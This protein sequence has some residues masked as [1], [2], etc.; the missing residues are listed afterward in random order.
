MKSDNKR[1]AWSL[2]PCNLI[3]NGHAIEESLFAKQQMVFDSGTSN[4]VMSH[5]LA[6]VSGGQSLKQGKNVDDLSPTCR[7]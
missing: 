4:I 6:T 3:V 2:S 7:R 5:K 1:E